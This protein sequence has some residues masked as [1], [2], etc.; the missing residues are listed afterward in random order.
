M[1]VKKESYALGLNMAKSAGEIGVELEK[2]SFLKGISDFIYGKDLEL[3]DEE[4][5]TA[6]QS[7]QK[8]A[9]ASQEAL[10]SKA[11]SSAKEEGQ[12]FLEAN[13]KKDGIVITASG[14]Q[15]E[16]IHQSNSGISPSAENKVTVH[17]EGKLINGTVFDSSFQR[18]QPATFQ[19]NQVIA[20]W[21]EGLQLMSKGDVYRL[22]IPSNLA[23]GDRG[24][25]NVIP[26]GATLIFQVELLE[27]Q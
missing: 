20:G 13:S 22:Y 9:Q 2:D 21:T 5:H 27:V 24:A 4:I 8:K 17:Y 7:L 25:S 11:S 15:Y 23:Y 3:S 18:N 26:P 6:L 10:Q 19:L 12:A 14:L 1:D 16:I